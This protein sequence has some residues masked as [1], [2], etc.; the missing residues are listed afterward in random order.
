MQGAKT[1]FIGGYAKLPAGITASE[2]Y[3]VVGVGLVVNPETGIIVDADCTLATR[4][5]RSFVAE[6][7]MGRK[8]AED[9]DFIIEE[10]RLRYHG[11]AQKALITALKAASEKFRALYR[12]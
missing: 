4:T 8:L 2:I 3:K 5:G 1:I 11:T 9:L 7:L 10:L 6:L 12:T